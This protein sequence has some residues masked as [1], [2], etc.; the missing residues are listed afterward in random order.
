MKP[1][2]KVQLWQSESVLKSALD[3]GEERWR[4]TSQP[5]DHSAFIDG[6]DLFGD[7]LG[8]K[9][10]TRNPL[11]YDRVTRREM[12]RVLGQG[13]NN[14]KLAELIDAII[15]ENDDRPGLFDLDA[16]GRVEICHYDVTPLIRQGANHHIR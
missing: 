5:F 6:F 2:P 1:T 4:Q 10:E 8:R 15:G 13:D 3:L 7:G 9:R 14:H 11:G 16:D 12:C